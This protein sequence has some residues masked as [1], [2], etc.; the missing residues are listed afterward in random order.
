M[1][2]KVSDRD[3][4][5]LETALRTAI[6]EEAL[7]LHYQP[8]ARGALREGEIMPHRASKRYRARRVI[9]MSALLYRWICHTYERNEKIQSP[10][11]SSTLLGRSGRS[12][13]SR[14]SVQNP[15]E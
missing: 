7:V 10:Y 4:P 14:P 8:V 1:T 12:S 2:T 9:P 6:K 3:N 5:A 15:K 13:R 11:G